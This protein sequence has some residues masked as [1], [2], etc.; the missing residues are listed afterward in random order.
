[1]T[2]CTKV[3]QAQYQNTICGYFIHLLT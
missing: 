1:L 2:N 3:A